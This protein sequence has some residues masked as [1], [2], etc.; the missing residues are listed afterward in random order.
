MTK[1]QTWNEATR[2]LHELGLKDKVLD[3]AMKRF[4][5]L[6]APK[7]GGGTAVK[8]IEFEGTLYYYCRF[9]GLYFPEEQMVFQNDEMRAAKKHKGYSKIGFSLW[10]KCNKYVKDIKMQ[11][12]EIAYGEDQSDET[13]QKGMEL[14]NKAKDIES[15]GRANDYN[16]LMENFLTDEQAEYLETLDLPLLSE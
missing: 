11:S 2:I 15:N 10:S 5:V 16:F 4:E 1:Q 12:V 3:T 13:R 14:M 9:T 7:K 6:L 8:P